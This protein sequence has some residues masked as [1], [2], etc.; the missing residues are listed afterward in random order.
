MSATALPPLLSPGSTDL[1]SPDSDALYD[2]NEEDGVVGEEGGD[3][4]VVYSNPIGAATPPP[5][6][7]SLSPPSHFRPGAS[8]S[9]SP[10]LDPSSSTPSTSSVIMSGTTKAINYCELRLM[11][12][13]KSRLP[14]TYPTVTPHNLLS[15]K[16]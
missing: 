13:N 7:S 12:L 5:T 2:E 14:S 16:S 4:G 8:S 3:R 11:N 6:V 10:L 9:R 1:S 15:R